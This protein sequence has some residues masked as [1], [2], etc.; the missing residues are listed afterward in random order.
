MCSE[1]AP[2][3]VTINAAGGRFSRA[4]VFVGASVDLGAAASFED[5]APRSEELL[6][7]SGAAPRRRNRG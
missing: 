7:M 4:E 5:L 3:G 6:D 1:D 2:N